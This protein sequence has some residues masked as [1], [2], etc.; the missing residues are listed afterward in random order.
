MQGKQTRMKSKEP[1]LL[2]SLWLLTLYF[3][4]ENIK[5]LKHETNSLLVLS[6]LTPTTITASRKGHTE[7]ELPK[8]FW[9]LISKTLNPKL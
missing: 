9:H 2:W 7:P 6:N 1:P 3:G 5:S 4:I 8:Q